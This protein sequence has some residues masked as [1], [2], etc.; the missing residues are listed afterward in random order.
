MLNAVP[1]ATRD[2]R[3]RP[4]FEWSPAVAAHKTEAESEM[5]RRAGMTAPTDRE[6]RLHQVLEDVGYF[7][8][9]TSFM[10]RVLLIW[11]GIA[12]A[13]T[14]SAANA[15][16]LFAGTPFMG[17]Y[18]TGIIGLAALGLLATAISTLRFLLQ[19]LPGRAEHLRSQFEQLQARHAGPAM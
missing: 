19:Q 5:L 12:A 8:S 16:L 4:V 11:M 1:M 3:D 9:L 14:I 10:R 18:P 6:E 13:L 2:G 15:I 7:V 17:P